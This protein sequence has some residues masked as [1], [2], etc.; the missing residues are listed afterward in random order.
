MTLNPQLNYHFIAYSSAEP[1]AKYHYRVDLTL[2]DLTTELVRMGVTTT[3][4]SDASSSCP[5]P[6]V[7][8]VG[9]DAPAAFRRGVDAPI[10]SAAVA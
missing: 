5:A 3:V 2:P 4:E 6:I 8:V 7:G 9:S 1:H 10:D